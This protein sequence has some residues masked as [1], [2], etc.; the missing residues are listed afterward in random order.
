[1][2]TFLCFTAVHIFLYFCPWSPK[3]R[4]VDRFDCSKSRFLDRKRPT[5]GLVGEMQILRLNETRQNVLFLSVNLA[6]SKGC[7]ASFGGFRAIRWL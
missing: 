5:K 6:Q 4:G 1:M 2:R 7:G 3:I